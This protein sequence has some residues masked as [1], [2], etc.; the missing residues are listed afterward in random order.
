MS[1]W[2]DTRDAIVEELKKAA[3][4]EEAKQRVTAAVIA[5]G[6]PVM[7]AAVEG[8]SAKLEEDSMGDERAWVRWGEG[9][10]LPGLLRVAMWTVK[11]IL[12]KS[13]EAQGKSAAEPA[14]EPG[15]A[16]V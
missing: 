6:L 11:L 1:K 14:G 12:K 2:T 13:M 16:E 4:S 9:I 10:V 7:E 15:N 3:M 8:Y 5:E